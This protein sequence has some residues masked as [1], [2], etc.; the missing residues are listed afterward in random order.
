[1]TVP[2]KLQQSSSLIARHL[3]YA[4]MLQGTRSNILV[5]LSGERF[6]SY[7]WICLP[8]TIASALLA[9]TSRSA[10][11]SGEAA[12]LVHSVHRRPVVGILFANTNASEYSLIEIDPD[13]ARTQGSQLRA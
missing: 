9:Y 7:V 11:C 6:T 1:M 5:C 8:K 12:V 13:E 2:V 3:K 4:G 10:G